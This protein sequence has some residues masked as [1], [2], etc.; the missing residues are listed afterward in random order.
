MLGF[1]PEISFKHC[2]SLRVTFKLNFVITI[3]IRSSYGL[4]LHFL[5]LSE[6]KSHQ[7]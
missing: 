7:L 5:D 6:T 2:F 1:K 4:K 3:G